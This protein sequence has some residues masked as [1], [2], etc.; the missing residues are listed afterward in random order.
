MDGLDEMVSN[1][2]YHARVTKSAVAYNVVLLFQHGSKD[3]GDAQASWITITP[4]PS[5]YAI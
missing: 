3:Y 4:P 5:A 2:G 1:M